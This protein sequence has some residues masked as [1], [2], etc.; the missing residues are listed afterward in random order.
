MRLLDNIFKLGKTYRNA[1]DEAFEESVTM[2]EAGRQPL[3]FLLFFVVWIAMWIA[4]LFSDLG[5]EES[6]DEFDLYP[7]TFMFAVSY[8]TFFL[9]SKYI[10]RPTA[11]E[12]E[13]D[14]S[15]F[16]LFS[17]CTR[18]EMRSLISIALAGLCSLLLALCLIQH[19]TGWF[20]FQ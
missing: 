6:V 1:K 19:D 3:L 7:I 4:A 16:A 10:F 12:L 8:F 13:D 14:T 20:S 2:L 18:R 17:A 11:E 15:R 5:M 9:G